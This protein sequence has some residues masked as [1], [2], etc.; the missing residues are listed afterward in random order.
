MEAV[1]D[2]TDALV[3]ELEET[4]EEKHEI[5]QSKHALGEQLEHEKQNHAETRAHLE[6]EITSRDNKLSLT[7]ERHERLKEEKDKERKDAN[8]LRN[9][10]NAKA[11]EM[12]RLMQ[13]IDEA[14]SKRAEIYVRGIASTLSFFMREFLPSLSMS[15]QIQRT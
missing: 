1:Q 9:E 2:T 12:E 10:L 5:E 8:E 7:E 13:E 14:V 4:V 15:R 11:H 3:D 6:Q